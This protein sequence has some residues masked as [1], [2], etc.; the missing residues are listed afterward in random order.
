ME[1]AVTGVKDASLD[2]DPVCRLRD[3]VLLPKPH[4]AATEVGFY[5]YANHGAG[6]RIASLK[7]L[8]TNVHEKDGWEGIPAGR[9][10]HLV[11]RAPL[12]IRNRLRRAS[13]R[14]PGSRGDHGK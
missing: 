7:L 13:R 11:T 5:L 2:W 10:T 1:C 8:V 3:P 14:L 12:E 4:I 6:E 9:K